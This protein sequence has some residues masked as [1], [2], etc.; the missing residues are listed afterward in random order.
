MEYFIFGYNISIFNY[1]Q[2]GINNLFPIIK[3][4]SISEQ[5]KFFRVIFNNIIVK[6]NRMIINNNLESIE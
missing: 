5:P 4:C 1:F 3:N 6:E 2:S